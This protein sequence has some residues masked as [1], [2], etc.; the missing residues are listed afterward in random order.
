MK[1]KIMDIDQALRP[2]EKMKSDGYEVLSNEELLAILISTGSKGKNAIELSK[3]I[4]DK[5]S[6][7]ELISI[8]IE[9]LCQIDGIKL[10]KASKIIAAIQFGKRL[11]ES[12]LNRE[13]V[14]ISSSDD[15]YR[16][17]KNKFIDTKKEHFYAILLDTKNVIISKELIS[18]GDLNSSIVNPRECFI[19]AVR[20]SAKSVIFVH[21]H[22]SGNTKPSQSD[23]EIT[24]RLREAGRILDIEMLDHIIIGLDEYYSFRKENFNRSM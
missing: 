16:L 19:K 2:R 10:A 11:S 17:M 24:S 5:F 4:L 20:K 13:I 18:T 22:P 14:K 9:E 8:T 21:N 7:D 6:S 23:I 15:V 3:E 12:I 1:K